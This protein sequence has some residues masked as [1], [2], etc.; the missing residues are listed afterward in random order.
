VPLTHVVRL[1]RAVTIGYYEKYWYWSALYCTVF[2]ALTGYFALKR[3]RKR[4]VS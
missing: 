1:V 3:L 2:I 4:L